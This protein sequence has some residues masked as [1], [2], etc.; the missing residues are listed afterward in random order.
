[1]VSAI[2]EGAAGE[3]IREAD[4]QDSAEGVDGKKTGERSVLLLFS[5]GS[6]I[7]LFVLTPSWI[8][9]KGGSELPPPPPPISSSRLRFF[10]PK[11]LG[12]GIGG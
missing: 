2:A 12:V 6:R 7:G 9:T 1:M 11:M 10:V 3:E 8:R 5:A 4:G